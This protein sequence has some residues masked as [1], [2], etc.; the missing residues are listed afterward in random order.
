MFLVMQACG[1][2]MDLYDKRSLG[3][4]LVTA[5]LARLSS[6][7]HQLVQSGF[8]SHLGQALHSEHQ[9]VLI[10]LLRRITNGEPS[11]EEAGRAV[12]TDFKVKISS[13][14]HRPKTI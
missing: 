4:L 13:H 11:Q 2:M 7:Q 8:T 5:F 10:E 9:M 14:A 6:Q 1:R 12:L 3:G